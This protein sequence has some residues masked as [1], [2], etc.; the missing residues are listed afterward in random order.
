MRLLLHC[1]LRPNYN[2]GVS[3][4]HVLSTNTAMGSKEGLHCLQLQGCITYIIYTHN[5]L[6]AIA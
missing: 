3:L 4:R 1:T 2:N 5:L 6:A